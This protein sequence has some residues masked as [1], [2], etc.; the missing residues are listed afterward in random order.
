MRPGTSSGG[1]D[2]R[3]CGRGTGAVHAAGVW[4]GQRDQRADAGGVEAGI[5]ED[6]AGPARIDTFHDQEA[7][8]RFWLDGLAG[9]LEQQLGDALGERQRVGD[10][11]LT[12]GRDDVADALAGAGAGETRWPV[13]HRRVTATATGISSSTVVIEPSASI[14][15][16]TSSRGAVSWPV[17]R[18]IVDS[19]ARI[20]M[21]R[22]RARVSNVTNR[23]PSTTGQLLGDLQE[24]GGDQAAGQL[25]L[26]KGF[27]TPG[28]RL[29]IVHQGETDTTAGVDLP[30]GAESRDSRAPR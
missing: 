13:G 22:G 10:N 29:V 9:G 17:A 19:P 27:W 5:L 25:I 20:W 3:G 21:R 15:I 30:T 14:L 18:S 7:L 2:H 8:G 16:R 12:G 1:R 11:R 26:V 23:P 28:A 4:G 24:P 6:L